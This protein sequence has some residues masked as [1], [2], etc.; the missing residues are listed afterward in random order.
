MAA[1]L[2]NRFMGKPPPELPSHSKWSLIGDVSFSPKPRD[3]IRSFRIMAGGGS[4]MY[5]FRKKMSK[6][7]RNRAFRGLVDRFEGRETK[8]HP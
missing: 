2:K 3:F 5:F 8:T 4:C 1:R 7:S 6:T